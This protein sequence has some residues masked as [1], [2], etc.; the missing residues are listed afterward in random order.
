MAGSFSSFLPQ[1]KRQLLS[2]VFPVPQ[3]RMTNPPPHRITL[4]VSS[5][6]LKLHC[7]LMGQEVRLR[8]QSPTP[9]EQI[10]ALPF[11]AVRPVTAC[12]LPVP[13]FPHL[14]NGAAISQGHERN[15]PHAGCRSSSELRLA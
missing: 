12:G 2:K 13:P 7:L 4:I 8:F 15:P 10:S 11:L 3:L 9:R 1:V 5:E 6:H 14:C